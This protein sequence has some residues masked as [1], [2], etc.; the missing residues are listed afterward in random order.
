MTRF[1]IFQILIG[2]GAI[3]A[4]IGCGDAGQAATD[5]TDIVDA[6]IGDDPGAAVGLEAEL[7]L[8]CEAVCDKMRDCGRRVE[9]SECLDSCFD[10]YP[11]DLGEECILA[12]ID[13]L[14]C[15]S[16]S[17]CTV[18]LLD[19]E[20]SEAMRHAHTSCPRAEGVREIIE[21]IGE[22]LPAD[23][24]ETEDETADET[25]EDPI[26]VPDFTDRVVIPEIPTEI[27]PIDLPWIPVFDER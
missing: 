3:L 24:D 18:S 9:G 26:E 25:E 6:D 22:K 2:S 11:T 4:A 7:G 12:Q 15:S 14:N 19:D 13:L 21:E 27:D 10:S 16:G 23:S 17:S 8:A 20:C 5:V 1:N